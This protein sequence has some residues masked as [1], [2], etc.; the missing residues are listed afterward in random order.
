MRLVDLRIT[1]LPGL[2]P[3]FTVRLEP[4]LNLITGPNGSGKSSLARALFNLLWPELAPP[5]EGQP[6]EAAATFRWNGQEWRAQ[7]TDGRRVHWTCDGQDSAGPDLPSAGVAPAYRLGFL[8]LNVPTPGGDDRELAG[9]IRRQMDGGFD[10]RLTRDELFPLSPR[11][12]LDQLRKLQDAR[13]EVRRLQTEHQ[14]L[15]RQRR[16]LDQLEAETHDAL[17]ARNRAE[18]WST[19]LQLHELQEK[20][21][22]A[23]ADLEA[24]P[25]GVARVQADDPALLKQLRRDQQR[26]HLQLEEAQ[27]E[28]Q[29]NEETR[30]QLALPADDFAAEL[31]DELL[32]LLADLERRL[33]GQGPA[34]GKREAP[35]GKPVDAEAYLRLQELVARRQVL[36]ARQESL[37]REAGLPVAADLPP[38]WT[39]VLA[40]VAGGGWLGAGIW[41]WL[42]SP[43]QPLGFIFLLLAGPTLAGAV[44][45]TMARRRGEAQRRRDEL[46]ADLDRIRV[47]LDEM[48]GE[49][50]RLGA[51]YDLDL[52]NPSLLHDLKSLDLKLEAQ[53]RAAEAADLAVHMQ[54]QRKDLLRRLNQQLAGAGEGPVAD[55]AQAR[56]CRKRLQQRQEKLVQAEADGRDLSRK[57]ATARTD[58]DRLQEDAEALFRRLSL[59]PGPDRDQQVALLAGSMADRAEAA[60]LVTRLEA[61]IR[62]NEDLLAKA[63]LGM[64]L[65]R[66]RELSPDELRARRDED[67]RAAQNEAELRD[68]LAAVRQAIAHALAGQT[69]EAAGAR[70]QE[71]R[72]DLL[73]KRQHAHR[74]NLGRLLL[75]RVESQSESRSR[76]PVLAQADT[77][78]QRFTGRRYAL[79]TTTSPDGEAGFRARDLVSGDILA[80]E[81]LSDGTRAQLLLAVRLGFILNSETSCRPP[82]FLDDCLSA[83]DPGRFAAIATALEELVRSEDRQI[84]FLTPDPADAQ[85]LREMPDQRDG[86]ALTVVDLAKV[87]GL[88][89]AA[90]AEQLRQPAIAPI[91]APGHRSPEQY[92]ELLQVPRL[93]PWAP[94]TA[95]HLFYLLRDRLDLLHR[96]LQ[97]GCGQVGPWLAA[98]RD[99]EDRRVLTGEEARFL[100]GRINTWETTLQAWRQGRCRPVTLQ[101]LDASGAVSTTM[102]DRLIPVLAEVG[103]QGKAL[104]EALRQSRVRR[105]KEAKIN[106]L[107]EHLEL[108]QL[109]PEGHPLSEDDL[110]LRVLSTP[111][112]TDQTEPLP[113]REF[114]LQLTRTLDEG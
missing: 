58:L 91:P 71:C 101:D 39:A 52:R 100:A 28:L 84:L 8:D 77:L 86:S 79:L 80:T 73:E 106:Q 54:Q 5:P 112:S 12:G 66:A 11:A 103:G 96:L 83:S 114:I 26:A 31:T 35:S 44:A 46:E 67:A 50:G 25:P 64:D 102:R 53:H 99:L 113:S 43:E 47:E 32:E 15:D 63:D 40:W 69:M 94:A 4:G 30:R 95:A 13:R 19:L 41:R 81:G 1:R 111:E 17:A 48:D 109:L 22:Q 10:V 56:A 21:R 90:P 33:D 75:S 9:R 93:D 60:Q 104:L 78:L 62:A 14:E 97:A 18:A 107:Q 76:P 49:L 88:S 70:A 20:L 87:R 85:A 105:F 108:V 6:W 51:Q 24:F 98:R 74:T 57:L 65:A 3:E 55:G 110:V 38:A 23:R 61:D 27:Q 45:L 36:A 89:R 68:R 72:E 29:A 37:Q 92:G 7:T 2:H 59:S 82:L 16:R 34:A 42:A